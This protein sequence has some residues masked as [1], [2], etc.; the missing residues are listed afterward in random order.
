[1]LACGRC[2]GVLDS[3]DLTS[4]NCNVFAPEYNED[5]KVE[6]IKYVV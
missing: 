4:H 1:M 6:A 2:C 5:R 3:D